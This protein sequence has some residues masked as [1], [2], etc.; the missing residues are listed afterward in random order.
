MCY[1]I[2]YALRRFPLQ[3][4]SERRRPARLQAPAGSHDIYIY[5]CIYIYIYICMYVY[6]YNHY[7][8]DY[9]MY[10]CIYIYIYICIYIYIYIYMDLT[11][12][13][14]QSYSIIHVIL[15]HV[16]TVCFVIFLYDVVRCY[17]ITYIMTGVVIVYDIFGY[18]MVWHIT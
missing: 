11:I 2:C 3:S 15:R 4:C 14:Y 17:A 12:S 9:Y 10:M 16:I 13:W 8:Y 7:Y 1:L 5:I 18:Y 6:M